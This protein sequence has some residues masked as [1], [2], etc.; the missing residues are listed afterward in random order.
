MLDVFLGLQGSGLATPRYE[1]TPATS[2][3]AADGGGKKKRRQYLDDEGEVS[4][5]ETLELALPRP[6][7]GFPWMVSCL[8]PPWAWFRV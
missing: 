3:S 7:P 5:E 8:A 1:T 4:N 2:K 6:C